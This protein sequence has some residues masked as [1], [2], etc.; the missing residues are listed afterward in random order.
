MIGL[1]DG[2]FLK[3]T[4]NFKLNIHFQRDTDLIVYDEGQVA[5]V[6]VEMGFDTTD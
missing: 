6:G 5:L 4:L 1:S 2:K 3:N